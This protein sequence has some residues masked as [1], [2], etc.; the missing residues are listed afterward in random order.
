M[1]RQRLRFVAAMTLLLAGS[2]TPILASGN[3]GAVTFAMRTGTWFDPYTDNPST[4]TQTWLRSHFWR[5]QSTSPYFDSRLSWFPNAWVYLDLYGIPTNSPL[6]GQHPDWILKD[7][8]GKYMYIPFACNGTSCSQ[9]ALD[10]G[11][12][13]FRSYWVSQA[14]AILARGYKGMWIDDVNLSFRV[15]NGAGTQI[16]PRDPRT[17][18]T[19]TLA[20]W[21]KYVA[22]FTKY[23]RTSIPSTEIVH[24]S[25]W[26]AGANY[27]AYNDA[28]VIEEIQQADYIDCE[29]GVSDS[30][31]TGGTGF[32][33]LNNFF[34]FVDKV[35]SLGKHVVFDEYKTNGEYGLAGYFLI[36]SGGDAEADQS[37]T[38]NNWWAGYNVNIGTAQG[39][40]YNWNNLLRRDFSGGMVL[41]NPPQSASVTV[42]LPKSYQR[43][44]GSTVSKI[45]L[46]AGQGAVLI[47]PSTEIGIRVDSGSSK[48]QG[49]FSVDEYVTGGSEAS[50]AG[51]VATTGVTDPAPE[52]VYQTK[53]TG[54]AP[55]SY[56]FPVLT[57][58]HTYT[59]RLHF[60]DDL[61]SAA[62]QRVF[63][64][65]IN[66]KVVLSNFDIFGTA[67][68]KLKAVV[69]QFSTTPDNNG[70][71]TIEFSPISGK[72]AALISGIEIVP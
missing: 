59:V 34:S 71:I 65:S 24:N 6:V 19:M 42:T 12:A 41:L 3:E 55:F 23:I 5:M 48:A 67:K 57:A 8:N 14:K 58:G 60:A 15:S 49:E 25:I 11:N 39:A 45:T 35:H 46:A 51:A 62:G 13:S 66:G 2:V 43:I 28:N 21:E 52:S 30:G 36:S 47:S 68:A 32:W 1:K 18:T 56:V 33:S 29:R 27:S 31:L 69:E 44:S 50:F 72:G 64:V 54:T 10:P 53:R 61:S 7:S 63:N 20:N 17:G 4:S 70:E 26:F 40:R 22:D 9:Y 38:P 37:M 16:A